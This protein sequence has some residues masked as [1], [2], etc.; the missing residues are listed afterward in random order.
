MGDA[1][2]VDGVSKRFRVYHERNQSLKSAVM[3]RG[4]GTYED[5][6]ALDD[7]SLAIP[8][9][10]TFA[11]VGDNG[12]GKSTLLKCLAQILVPDAGKVTMNGR[13]AALLEVGSGFHPELSGRDNVYLNGSILGMTRQE[14]DRKFDAIVDFSGVEQFIDQPVKNYSSGMYVRLGFSVAINVD[15]EI[16]L[17]DEVLAVGD[18]AFQAKCTEKFAQLNR[19]GRTVVL[20]SHSMPSVRAMADRA[21]WLAG[22][23]LQA[24]GLASTVLESYE[25]STRGAT[26]TAVVGGLEHNGSGEIR[27]TSVDVL[28]SDG[29]P[30]VDVGDPVRVRIAFDVA[31]PVE[32]PVIGFAVEALDGTYL[33]AT[34][35]RD[36]GVPLG[37]VDTAGVVECE[38]PSVQLHPGDFI[39]TAAVTDSTTTHSIDHVRDV[40]RFT[41]DS[42]D[43]TWSGGYLALPAAWGPVGV[44]GPVPRRSA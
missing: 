4:R 10:S 38:L 6:L 40:A 18:A 28:G 29:R 3:R 44:T 11:L 43:R 20:V 30:R 36:A 16:L 8:E 9:S 33:A 27:I 25:E 14:I 15:P 39:V 22:G 31:E 41:V 42:G 19:E 34:N 21:A 2:V 12:S 37:L 24:V 5:F 26:G 23:H 32:N 1:I 13:V 17:V 35:T 7:V